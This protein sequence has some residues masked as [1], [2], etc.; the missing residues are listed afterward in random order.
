MGWGALELAA[1]WSGNCQKRHK[2]RL[3][4]PVRAWRCTE[5]AGLE[6]RM[7][8]FIRLRPGSA[9]TDA[10]G[11]LKPT[12]VRGWGICHSRHVMQVL[13]PD[14]VSAA[15]WRVKLQRA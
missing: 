6:H 15:P 13:K 2:Q 8:E 11:A 9:C 4:Q 1:G 14:D 10:R 5:G 3:G 7:P 12:A